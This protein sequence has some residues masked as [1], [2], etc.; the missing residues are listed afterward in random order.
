MFEGYVS[1]IY[2][3]VV[4]LF[5]LA[6]LLA[7]TDLAPGLFTKSL[8]RLL[9]R[10]TRVVYGFILLLLLLNWAGVLPRALPVRTPSEFFSSQTHTL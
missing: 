1:I 5:T 4:L 7:Y 6:N 8:T 3:G 9:I 10:F 2:V